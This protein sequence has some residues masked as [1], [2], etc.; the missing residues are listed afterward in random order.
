[1]DLSRCTTVLFGH[2]SI[3]SALR[4]VEPTWRNYIQYVDMESRAG[5]PDAARYLSM[6][7]SLPPIE[8]VSHVPEQ[9]C[10]LA[11]VTPADLMSWV[12]RQIWNEGSAQTSMVLSFMR[13]R[14]LRNTAEFAM[15]SPDNYKHAE[16]FMKS[17]GM[18]PTAAR[19]GSGSPVT[20]FNAPVAS[21]G[22]VALAGSRSES[23]P[24]HASGL[25]DMDSEIVELSK[26]MQ[27]GGTACAAEDE[28]REDDD[29]DD[30]DDDGDEED[31]E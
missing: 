16:L 9:I 14:V 19:A 11:S 10:E 13:A 5:N 3:T 30:D 15:A 12:T 25:R 27:T 18:L 1:M 29:E 20:I 26:I 31:D 23:T 6:W 17:A 7:H 24:V 21:S 28:D 22:S 8:R 2:T 4:Y